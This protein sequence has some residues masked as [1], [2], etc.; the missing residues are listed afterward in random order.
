M[1]LTHEVALSGRTDLTKYAHNAHLLFALEV[2]FQIDDIHS[3]ATDALTDGQYDKKCDV[4]YVDTDDGV[5]VVAQGYVATNPKSEAPANKASDLNTAIAWVFGAPMSVIPP[6]LQSAV[7]QVRAA[8]EADQLRTIQFWYVHNCPESSNVRAELSRVESSVKAA[9]KE[10]FPNSNI[11]EFRAME[12]GQNTLEDWYKALQAPIL[13]TDSFEI[14]LTGGHTESGKDWEAFVTSV[15]GN[16]LYD[17]YQTHDS[18]LFSANLRGYLGYNRR[19]KNIN[20]GIRQTAEGEPAQFWVFNNGITALVHDFTVDTAANKLKVSGIS[21]VN[22]AQTTGSLG[23]LSKAPVGVR[24]QA[25]IVK[26]SNKDT[27]LDIIKYNNSQNPLASPDFR[28]NDQIQRRLRQEFSTIPNAEYTGGRRGIDVGKKA[29]NLLS[30]DTVAQALAACH[31]SPRTAYHERAKIW[32]NDNQYSKFF[33]DDTSAEHIVWCHSLLKSVENKKIEL[34]TR[35]A[36]AADLPTEDRDILS[37]MRR[38]GA[39]ILVTAAIA[40]CTE[41]ILDHSVPNLFKISFGR[42]VSPTTAEEFWEAIVDIAIPFAPFALESSLSRGIDQSEQTKKSIKQFVSL[43]K[44][45]AKT[46]KTIL[47]V[48]KSR[49]IV[50]T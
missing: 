45:T 48:F 30:S 7:T 33:T 12:V 16:L 17:L 28:S 36:S 47:E 14:P 20:H 46:N 37:L 35:E 49:V 43:F 8:L 3:V 5:L 34:V 13:V 42:S 44:S 41:T 26:C 4:I 27:I 32:L 22:G 23:A 18:R 24:V 6:P 31:D 40:A 9:V 15:D 38:R 10:H 1:A 29:T 50:A 21:I 11:S 25:R 39:T 19:D 2:A